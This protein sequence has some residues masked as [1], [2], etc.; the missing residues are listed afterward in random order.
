MYKHFFIT[1][2]IL[3]YG[4][5]CTLSQLSF[6][7]VKHD[8]GDLTAFSDRFV[9]VVIKNSGNKKEYILSV[10]KPKEVVYI[11][12]KQFIEKDSSIVLRFQ[13]NPSQKGKFNYTIDVFT[14]DKQ[15]A[16]QIKLSG[17]LK[18]IAPNETSA[19]TACPDFNQR[20]GGKNTNDFH[21]TVITIDKQTR[22]LL[23]NSSVVLLQNGQ[24]VWDKKTNK[25][26]EII[27]ES[28]LGFSYF[29][30]THD[31]YFPTELGA[32]INF[33][34]NY[35]VIELDQN[36]AMCL[37]ASI[38]KDTIIT[39]PVAEITLDISE[40]LEQELQN[41]QAETNIETPKELAALDN[42]NFD[43]QYFKP[44]NVV[45]VLDISSSMRQA[46]KLELMKYS[47]YQLVD[48]LRPQDKITLVTYS[49]DSRVL[50]S[51]TT[52]ADKEKINSA[53]ASLEASGYTAGG[54]GIKLG[55]KQA[56]KAFIPDGANQVIIITDGAFNRD[57]DDYLKSVKKYH[58]KG[59]TLSVVGVKNKDVDAEKM[60]KAAE[61]GGGRYIP[62]HKLS[63][64]NSNLKQ[65][66]RLSAFRIINKLY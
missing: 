45:F 2:L 49:S 10:K 16:S 48:M 11:V 66:I 3:L 63:D 4:S 44:V 58:K 33:N 25:N 24:P 28:T 19:F 53:V 36:P 41:E 57:S 59:I 38:L 14:S 6:D 54:E 31:G 62:I 65:E 34:R 56:Y 64:A 18:E 30:A 1:I 13:V 21:L 15:E 32:Y 51:T 7:K 39:E 42:N 20:P 52:C 40:S 26:G 60:K 55:F 8:F 46:D 37:P 22:G 12:Q 9:D 35:I 50:L 17:N 43:E 5:F 61:N 23:S 29:Y 27:E 47:L